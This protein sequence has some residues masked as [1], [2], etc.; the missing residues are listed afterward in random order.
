MRVADERRRA[1][2]H[3]QGFGGRLQRQRARFFLGQ[4]VAAEHELET[5]ANAGCEHFIIH[6]RKAWLQGLSPKENREIP[7][8]QY[9][10]V[11]R[12]KR[13]FPQL[14]I[15]LNGGLKT[16]E[17]CEQQL[18]ELDGVMLGREIY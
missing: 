8:L 18:A 3:S 15:V 4:A 12:L 2:R 6:A 5:V 1:R 9:E 7:P 17:A 14:T 13:E 10:V 11:H 16:L